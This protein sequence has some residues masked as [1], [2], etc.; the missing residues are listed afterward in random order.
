M[1]RITLFH[2]N[3]AEGEERAALLRS[4]GHEVELQSKVV[5][6]DLRAMGASPPH[7]VVIDL[8][9]APSHGREVAGALRRQKS[10]RVVPIIFVDGERDRV[11]RVRALLP[12]AQFTDWQDIADALKQASRRVSANPVVPGTMAGYSGTPLPKKLG[13]KPGLTVALLGAPDNF[14]ETLGAL[15]DGVHLCHEVRKGAALIL[16]FAKSQAMLQRRFPAAA[17]AL[18]EGGR[19]WILWPKKA[20]GV[21]TDLSEQ[22][23]RDHGL[24][25]AFVDYKIAAIDQTWSGLAF[26]RRKTAG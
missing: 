4:Q 3:A 13:I 22:I 9:R 2:W 11:A 8:S 25:R 7:G 26:A 1:S 5:P 20:S 19:L 24:D 6:A 17:K 12:D 23:V 21:S 10:T 16:L 15:P 14:D 18:A